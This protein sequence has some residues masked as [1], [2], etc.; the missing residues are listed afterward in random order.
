M[1]VEN[2][3]STEIGPARSL[4]PVKDASQGSSLAAA[5]FEA[6][7]RAWKGEAVDSQGAIPMSPVGEVDWDGS[8]GLGQLNMNNPVL[9]TEYTLWGS[10]TC[11]WECTTGCVTF[12]QGC[13]NVCT[14]PGWESTCDPSCQYG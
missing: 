1:T 2:H 14:Q 8:L 3:V 11:S 5:Q 4:A 12:A 9:C 10:F 6:I 7:I 13:S